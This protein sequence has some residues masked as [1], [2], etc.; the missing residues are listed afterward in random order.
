MTS[1]AVFRPQV[2]LLQRQPDS[3]TLYIKGRASRSAAWEVLGHDDDG[4][5]NADAAVVR[6]KPGSQHFAPGK[7]SRS[8]AGS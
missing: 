8:G 5:V 6:D 1:E 7:R 3:V 4:Q 2:E